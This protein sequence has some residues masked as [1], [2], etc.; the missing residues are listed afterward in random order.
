MPADLSMH[1]LYMDEIDGL[2]VG[3]CISCRAPQARHTSSNEA[4]FLFQSKCYHI[5]VNSHQVWICHSC[6]KEL[7][8][9]TLLSSRLNSK[10]LSGTVRRKVYG[11]SS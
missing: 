2:F 1:E 10:Y 6:K 7:D 3:S 4:W 8:K 9:G 11:N 5:S